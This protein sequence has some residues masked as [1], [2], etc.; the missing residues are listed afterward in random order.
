M[1]AS[2]SE[3][4]LRTIGAALAG[5][6]IGSGSMLA[7]GGGEVRVLGINHLAIFAKPRATASGSADPSRRMRAQRLKV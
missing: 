2:G 6:S 4:A 5:V 3:I 7:Y 1:I